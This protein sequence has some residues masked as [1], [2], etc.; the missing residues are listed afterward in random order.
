MQTEDMQNFADDVDEFLKANDV[1]ADNAAPAAAAKPAA[2]PEPKPQPLHMNIKDQLK[3]GVVVKI[4][5]GYALSLLP[6]PLSPLAITTQVLLIPVAGSWVAGRKR[7][8][9]APS[10]GMLVKEYFELRWTT[11]MF[12][13][14]SFT[15][16]V[17]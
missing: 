15:A 1:D 4:S 17:R 8:P 10:S 12:T 11:Q 16:S 14:P 6:T 9:R 5:Y 3:E 7:T 13:T 2:K